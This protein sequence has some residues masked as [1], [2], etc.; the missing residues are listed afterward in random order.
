[1]WIRDPPTCLNPLPSLTRILPI[2]RAVFLTRWAVSLDVTECQTVGCLVH[3]AQ[4]SFYWYIPMLM[5]ALIFRARH[6]RNFSVSRVCVS[7]DAGTLVQSRAVAF[8][9]LVSKACNS[10]H[11]HLLLEDLF[12]PFIKLFS[13]L[14]LF[15]QSMHCPLCIPPLIN[16]AARN[17]FSVEDTAQTFLASQ[18][19]ACRQVACS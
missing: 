1:M 11:P 6:P 13:S 18:L 12:N 9:S 7:Y 14:P 16:L 15:T 4:Y 5:L 2:S 3:T 10:S 19:P 17:S 8:T